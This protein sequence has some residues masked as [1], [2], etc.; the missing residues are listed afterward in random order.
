MFL[1]QTMDWTLKEITINLELL[2]K[3]VGTNKA[4]NS[5][6]MCDVADQT[7]WGESIQPQAILQDPGKKEEKLKKKKKF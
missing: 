6:G 2:C 4:A 5:I 7:L 3:C 1:I